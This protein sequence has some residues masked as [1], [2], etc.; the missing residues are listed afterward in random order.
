MSRAE[1]QP[2]S[3]D[4]L[5]P[6]SY[7]TKAK[8]RRQTLTFL[9][10]FCLVLLIGVAA[11]GNWLQW[12]NIGG[13]RGAVMCPV[14]TVADPGLTSVN[15][16]NATDR[17]GLAAAVAKELQHRAFLIKAVST[18]TTA[19]PIAAAAYIRYGNEGRIAAHTVALQFPGKI[20]LVKDGR[21]DDTVDVVLGQSYRGMVARSKAAKAIAMKPDPAGCTIVSTSSPGPS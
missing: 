9:A 6:R 12:W 5:L 7:Q 15:V 3:S 20:R 8:R 17:R 1:V 4:A 11:A 14:Q 21:D 2:S 10:L 18:Q 13:R 19:K 16:Y